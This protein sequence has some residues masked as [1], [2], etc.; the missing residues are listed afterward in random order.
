MTG[1]QVLDA[2]FVSMVIPKIEGVGRLCVVAGISH[3]KG[4][5]LV[6]QLRREIPLFLPSKRIGKIGF[7]VRCFLYL[8]C[9]SALSCSIYPHLIRIF[10]PVS[11][12]WSPCG[13]LERLPPCSCWA[14]PLWWAYHTLPLTQHSGLCLPHSVVVFVRDDFQNSCILQARKYVS[15]YQV[16]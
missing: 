5:G 12:G 11:A 15:W 7:H 14:V 3:S 9:V 8:Y 1:I 10:L 6:Q 16:G 2:T 13:G 4:G